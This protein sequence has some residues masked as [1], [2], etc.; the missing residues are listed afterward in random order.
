MVLFGVDCK[1]NG[2]RTKSSLLPQSS[3]RYNN[4]I[5]GIHLKK[6]KHLVILVRLSSYNFCTKME[7]CFFA[8]EKH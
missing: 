8:T 6:K 4:D 2:I 3:F 1:V 7:N 5:G